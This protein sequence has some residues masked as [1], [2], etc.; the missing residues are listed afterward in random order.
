MVQSKKAKSI[1]KKQRAPVA[2][3]LVAVITFAAVF[4]MLALAVTPDRYD[5]EVG[6][7]APNTIKATKDVEDKIFNRL[8]K[9]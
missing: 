5:I 1:K 6:Q 4:V 9:L 7:P 8:L 2:S 3:L